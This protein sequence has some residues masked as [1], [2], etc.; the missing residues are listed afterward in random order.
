MPPLIAHCNPGVPSKKPGFVVIFSS[1]RRSN[2]ELGTRTVSAPACRTSAGRS[3]S[4]A[5]TRPVRCAH[6]S[7]R[8]RARPRFPRSRR[9]RRSPAACSRGR[10]DRRLRR[11]SRR[12]VARPVRAGRCRRWRGRGTVFRETVNACIELSVLIEPS[13][14]RRAERHLLRPTSSSRPLSVAIPS[15]VCATSTR[16]EDA[17][18]PVA[19]LDDDHAEEA[20]ARPPATRPGACGTRT[21]R[22]G[23]RGS[24]TCRSRPADCVLGHAGDAVLGVR[25]VDAV[26]VDRHAL[27]DVL[28][29]RAR[30]RPGRPAGRGAPGRERSR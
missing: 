4:S 18:R 19:R 22:P 16:V 14:N 7:G 17:G 8:A 20:R 13:A 3:R 6:R 15:N 27:L 23:P 1:K 10:P 30:P 5:P 25:N 24:G 26:P 29:A 9:A 2:V 11:G 12:S 21:S 28:V